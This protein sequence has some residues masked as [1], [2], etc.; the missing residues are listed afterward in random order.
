MGRG[1]RARVYGVHRPVRR[2]ALVRSSFEIAP[3]LIQ[4]RSPW[5]DHVTPA[6]H[7]R[8]AL[9]FQ[10]RVNLTAVGTGARRHACCT[11]RGRAGEYDDRERSAV[12]GERHASTPSL[13]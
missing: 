13:A 6:V 8:E 9:L 5:L 11:L 12:R 3:T 2:R 10:C 7:L 1:L 4:R